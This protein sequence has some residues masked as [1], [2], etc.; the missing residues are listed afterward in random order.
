MKL[1]AAASRILL[2]LLLAS[3]PFAH[4]QEAARSPSGRPAVAEEHKAIRLLAIGNSFSADATAFL[5]DL[6]AAG[7]HTLFFGHVAV[8]AGTLD[9]HVRHALAHE[10]DPADPAGK[11]Y[12]VKGKKVSLKEILQSDD[13]EYVTIQQASM[14]SFN[15]DTYRPHAQQLTDYVLKYAPRAHVVLH[16]TWAYRADNPM[17]R[18]GKVTRQEMYDR[19]HAAYRA[20]AQEINAPGVIPVG[21]AFENALKDPRWVFKAPENVDR[22]AF[23]YPDLPAQANSLHVGYKWPAPSTQPTTKPAELAYDGSHASALGRYLGACT[24]YAFFYGDVRGNR[25]APDGVTPQQ[26]ATL[27]DIAHNTV[28][29]KA[30]APKELAAPSP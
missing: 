4:A 11:P 19:L 15:I 16:E 18:E 7:G 27:Q 8:P 14:K 5:D 29:A 9:G 2:A 22:T 23:T 1:A 13:W 3:A 30:P 17:F 10:K 26:A 20:I 21:T 24:W 28:N 12:T 25:F 6:A